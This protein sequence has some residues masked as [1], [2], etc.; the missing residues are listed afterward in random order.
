MPGT[1]QHT[2]A[3]L[4]VTQRAAR[5]LLLLG[6]PSLL[7]GPEQNLQN[8]YAHQVAIHL[9][10]LVLNPVMNHYADYR[11]CIYTMKSASLNYS[12]CIVQTTFVKLAL[13]IQVSSGIMIVIFTASGREFDL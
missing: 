4:A 10:P 9:F 11:T 12:G 6:V 1:G 3:G 13:V 5:C 8:T 2:G 7:H